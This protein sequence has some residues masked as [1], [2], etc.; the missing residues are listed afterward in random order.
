MCADMDIV[1]GLTLQQRHI[2]IAGQDVSL[3]CGV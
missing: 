1:L 2:S 3:R